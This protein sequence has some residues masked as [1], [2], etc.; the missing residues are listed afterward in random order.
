MRV[1][2]AKYNRFRNP[3]YQIQTTIFE[4]NGRRF[5]S[6]KALSKSSVAHL[7]RGK[8]NYHQLVRSTRGFC[9]PALVETRKNELIFEFIE[10][11]PVKD[12]LIDSLLAGDEKNFFKVIDDYYNMLQHG[13]EQGDTLYIAPQE[14]YIVEN[15]SRAEMTMLASEHVFL[16]QTYLDPIFSNIISSNR[17]SYLIDYE[18][19]LDSSLP[20]TFLFTRSLL[21][22]FIH[23]YNYLHPDRLFDEKILCQRF[24]LSEQQI[25]IFKKLEI[26]IQNKIHS[27]I[28]EHAR[29]VHPHLSRQVLIEARQNRK[30]AKQ[31]KAQLDRTSHRFAA[32]C[33]QGAEKT[34]LATLYR[35]LKGVTGPK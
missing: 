6:K 15:L 34:G 21:F 3:A 31:Y 14:L 7:E 24:S 16:K 17:S 4:E 10:G 25:R 9:F 32:F 13:F 2:S 22:T 11:R 19:V 30:K 33:N 26:N 8:Q 5:V 20:L 18:W 1:L 29:Y 23:R 28:Q 27:R 12:I 35:L